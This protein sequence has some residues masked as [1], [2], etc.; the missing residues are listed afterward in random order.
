MCMIVRYCPSPKSLFSPSIFITV[1]SGNYRE[2]ILQRRNYLLIISTLHQQHFRKKKVL[3]RKRGFGFFSIQEA[4][5]EI[6]HSRLSQFLP[7]NQFHPR[8]RNFQT[9]TDLSLQSTTFS[10]SN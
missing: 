10:F 4:I 1:H 2:N 7:V 3:R 9:E 8:T 5:W 6:G